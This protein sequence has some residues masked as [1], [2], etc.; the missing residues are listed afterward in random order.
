MRLY[1]GDNIFNKLTEPGLYRNNGL[2]SKAFGA[3]SNPENIEIKGLLETI[4]CHV[5][6]IFTE[7]KN[8]Y[9]VTD[10]LS[11]S[12]SSDRA[13]YWCSDRNTLKLNPSDDYQE[14]RYFFTLDLD[15]NYLQALG[16]SMY[17]YSFSCNPRLKTSDSNNEI[18]KAVFETLYATEV[19][20]LCK[21]KYNVHKILLI[22]SYDYL[23]THSS[24]SKYDGAIKFAKQD[25]EWLVLPC[26]PLGKHRSARIPR[27]DFW[28]AELFNV[29]AEERPDLG[30]L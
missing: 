29:D 30:Y 21:N 6:P 17:T 1:R 10:Y 14:T 24:H 26:D 8:Y 28:H 22:N 25:S 11:F 23:S 16:N 27:A 5:K 4:R 20:P 18:H 15:D 9:D 3:G 13:L 7:D 19:C 2:R 12:Y